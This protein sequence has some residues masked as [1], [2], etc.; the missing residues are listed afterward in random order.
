MTPTG[1]G[2]SSYKTCPLCGVMYP[3]NN[4]HVCLSPVASLYSTEYLERINVALERIAVAL[5]KIAE[6]CAK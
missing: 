1:A 5:E 6:G 3:L 4:W 2:S